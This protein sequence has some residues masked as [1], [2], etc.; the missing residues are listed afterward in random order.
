[1]LHTNLEGA[2]VVDLGTLCQLWVYN[3][4]I[5]PQRKGL[6]HWNGQTWPGGCMGAP[7]SKAK[8]A[9]HFVSSVY[10]GTH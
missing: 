3:N 4:L 1:M 8:K 9:D 5:G 6:Y 7:G 10:H 2:P